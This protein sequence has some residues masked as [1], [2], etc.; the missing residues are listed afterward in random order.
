MY[1]YLLVNFTDLTYDVTEC[2]LVTWNELKIQLCKDI[3]P[4][5]CIKTTQNF[6]RPKMP[7]FVSSHK[8]TPRSADLNPLHYTVWDNCNNFFEKEGMNHLRTQ[9]SSECYLRQMAWCRHQRARIAKAVCLWKKCLAAVAKENR[10][11][12]QQFFCWSVTDDLV[13]CDVL[14]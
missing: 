14:V 13:Y 7:D 3:V 4:S 5:H 1:S 11:S 10:G 9:R 12:I 8:W 6:L 2:R